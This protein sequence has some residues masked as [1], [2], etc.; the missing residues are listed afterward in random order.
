MSASPPLW[1][2]LFPTAGRLNFAIQAFSLTAIFL[3]GYDQGC[4]GGGAT[5][6][7]PASTFLLT[8][9]ALTVNASPDYVKTVGIGEFPSGKVYDTVHQGGIV[10]IYCVYS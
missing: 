6:S 8:F 1:K 2:R 7:R 5:R 4:M 9:A 3:E 10:S